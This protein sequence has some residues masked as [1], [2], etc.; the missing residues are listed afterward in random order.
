MP[1]TEVSE[2]MLTFAWRTAWFRNTDRYESGRQEY[3]RQEGDRLHNLIVHAGQH[4]ESLHQLVSPLKHTA[5]PA[6]AESGDLPGLF[7]P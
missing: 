4:I 2:S 5:W 6:A 3:H 7:L 1:G